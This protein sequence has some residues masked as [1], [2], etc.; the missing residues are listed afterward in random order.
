[1]EIFHRKLMKFWIQ[2]FLLGVPKIVVGFRDRDGFLVKVDEI[3]TQK[4][5][6]TINATPNP[7]WN[8]DLCVNFAGT[9]LECKWHGDYCTATRW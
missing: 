4:I 5:P 8:A 6:Q 9:F 1:M 2:S 3:E 7:S